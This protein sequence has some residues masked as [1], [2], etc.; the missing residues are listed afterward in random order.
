MLLVCRGQVLSS[1]S[2]NLSTQLIPGSLS[3]S[4]GSH[5]TL[6]DYDAIATSWGAPSGVARDA[7]CTVKTEV[8]YYSS[9]DSFVFVATFSA[10]GVPDVNAT[11]RLPVQPTGGL[12]INWD[13]PLAT[14]FPSWTDPTS[15]LSHISYAGNSL[16]NNFRSGNLAQWVGGIEGGPLLLYQTADP[17]D[18][19]ASIVISPL[20]HPKSMILSHT[21]DRVAIGVQGYVKCVHNRFLGDGRP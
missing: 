8:Q 2:P 4:R 7:A 9:Y 12:R 13:V 1:F 3:E 11:T 10:S 17:A 18:H 15:D 14:A 21:G 16:G 5:P 19:P 6:G 20:D